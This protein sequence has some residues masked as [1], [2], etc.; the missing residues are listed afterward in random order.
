MGLDTLHPKLRKRICF[1]ALT[2]CWLWT[3]ATL[4][5]HGQIRI[6]WKCYYTHRL[7][8]EH[9]KGPI[10][11]ELE[12]DHLCRNRA[13][14]N[15]DHLEAVTHRENVLR[16]TS[17]CAVRASKQTCSRGHIY[18]VLR[19]RKVGLPGRRCSICER[20]NYTMKD[21]CL[22]E[23]QAIAYT[24]HVPKRRRFA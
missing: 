19:A 21:R 2:G 5:G 11:P 22:T 13:C 4:K 7:V 10:P 14:C 15:P 12:I 8:Y 24:E 18:D 20:I 1:E 9:F 6:K 23:T 17:P 16:G 3:G